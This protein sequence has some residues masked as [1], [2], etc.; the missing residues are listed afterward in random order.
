MRDF[1]GT[2]GMITIA[3]DKSVSREGVDR[4]FDALSLFGIGASW[5]GFESLAMIAKPPRSFIDVDGL[6]TLIRFSIGLENV[7]DIIADLKRVLT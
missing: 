6:G 5:G 7:D 2:N 4:F 3:L 1:S